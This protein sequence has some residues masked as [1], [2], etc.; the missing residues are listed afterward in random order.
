VTGDITIGALGSDST[1]ATGNSLAT[2]DINSSGGATV[3]TGAIYMDMTATTAGDL[4]ST[5]NITVGSS[6][7][8]TL[9]A[10]DNEHG[11]TTTT[12]ANAGTI[13]AVSFLNEAAGGGFI[14][15]LTGSGSTTL[16][17]V[18]AGTGDLVLTS[19]GLGARIFTSL[20]STDNATITLSGSGANVITALDVS[21]N[22][23]LDVSGMTGTL[24]IDVSDVE[25]TLTVT[26]S[27]DVGFTSLTLMEA[28]QQA[29]VTLGVNGVTDHFITGSALTTATLTIANFKVGAPASGGDTID[30]DLTGIEAWGVDSDIILP[31]TTTSGA[32]NTHVLTE[33]SAGAYDL[34]AVTAGTTILV[35]DTNFATADMVKTA[36]EVGGSHALTMASV[37]DGNKAFLVA[38]DDGTNSYVAI[39]RNASGGDDIDDNETIPVDDLLVSNIITFSGVADVGTLTAANFGTAYI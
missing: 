15:T 2:I 7:T 36:L 30:L 14:G 8:G 5:V 24:T 6:S 17:S 33:L 39:A 12:I 4:A 11:V 29:T 21:D 38:Y 10:F 26:G 31:G 3:T 32:T 27:A 37:F 20:T 23:T 22:A 16:T 34:S 35:L 25:D 1:T 19:S 28:T 18:T 13:G 9:G